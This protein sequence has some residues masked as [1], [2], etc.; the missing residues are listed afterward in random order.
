MEKSSDSGNCKNQRVEKYTNYFIRHGKEQNFVFQHKTLI[1]NH[2]RQETTSSPK[3]FVRVPRI[4]VIDCLHE[5]DRTALS[6]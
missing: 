4:T 1:Y 3:Q 6:N 2:I 5:D